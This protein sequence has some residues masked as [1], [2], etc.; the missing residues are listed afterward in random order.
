MQCI[1][2]S[3]QRDWLRDITCDMWRVQLPVFNQFLLCFYESQCLWL[4]AVVLGKLIP[5]NF[6]IIF[7]NNNNVGLMNRY[8]NIYIT[9]HLNV[10]TRWNFKSIVE[11]PF[12]TFSFAVYVKYFMQ[13]DSLGMNSLFILFAGFHQD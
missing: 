6:N 12:W 11:Q 1:L 4:I 8:V 2:W 7:S 5:T 9:K 10:T 13:D 3:G